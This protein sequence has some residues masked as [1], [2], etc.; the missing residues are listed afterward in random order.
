[1]WMPLPLLPPCAVRLAARCRL[2]VCCLS[3]L[4]THCCCCLLL[5]LALP[6][7]LSPSHHG[8]FRS[9]FRQKGQPSTVRPQL[10]P[11]PPGNER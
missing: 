5:L 6:T 8:G 11:S 1:M 9:D 7:A 3:A 4:L 2:A 10:P